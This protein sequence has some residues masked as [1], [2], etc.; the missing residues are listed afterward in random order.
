MNIGLGWRLLIGLL[1]ILFALCLLWAF[2]AKSQP[3][4]CV[5]DE[6]RVHIRDV[7]VRAVDEAYSEQVRHLFETWMRDAT[8]QPK[9]AK[10]GMQNAIGGYIRARRDTLAWLPPRC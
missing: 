2:E 7:T 6:E 8:D 1:A 4:K 3:E 5:T 9:R 10:V